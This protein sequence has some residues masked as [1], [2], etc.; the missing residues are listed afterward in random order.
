M[1]NEVLSAIERNLRA[2]RHVSSET[3]PIEKELGSTWY[4]PSKDLTYKWVNNNGVYDWELITGKRSFSSAGD[5]SPTDDF[6]SGFETCAVWINE[7]TG[8]KFTLHDDTPGA[9]VWVQSVDIMGDTMLGKL[10]LSEDPT[11]NMDATTKQY[12]DIAA[13]ATDQEAVEDIVGDMFNGPQD[14]VS[15]S[16]DDTNGKIKIDVNDPTITLAGAATGTAVMTDL[17]NITI[18]T[19]I[20]QLDSIL[21]VDTTGSVKGD[22]LI[23]DTIG[24]VNTGVLDAGSF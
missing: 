15:V 19:T 8:K 13:A 1:A 7:T 22:I 20:P 6:D 11:G 23:R 9:A 21:D 2:F 16:Y 12:V 18:N 17:G 4:I 5:P 24:W 10:T 14:G 3:E